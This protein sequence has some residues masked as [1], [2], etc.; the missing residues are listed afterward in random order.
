V[1]GQGLEHGEDL[2]G[3]RTGQQRRV[4]RYGVPGRHQLCTLADADRGAGPAPHARRTRCEGAAK[5][6]EADTLLR[7][8]DAGVRAEARDTLGSDDR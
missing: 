7:P 8:V 4:P 3:L 5:L 2:A 6:A 1:R